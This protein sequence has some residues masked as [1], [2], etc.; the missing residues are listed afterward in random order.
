MIDSVVALVFFGLLTRSHCPVFAAHPVANTFPPEADTLPFLGPLYKFL[1]LHPRNAVRRV[2]P[3]VSFIPNFL[4]QS[5][6]I[7]RHY[8]C[9]QFLD[10]SSVAPRVDAQASATRTGIGGWFPYL[11][12]KGS[13][14]QWKS[15]WFSLEV[16][17]EV[18]TWIYERGDFSFLHSKHL[19][20]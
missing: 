14:D 20:Y 8:D 11:D 10:K 1:I 9:N 7:G 18:F 4:S 17:P 12:E 6:S 19:L 16:T 5:V 13:I 15:P 3:Y 2:P